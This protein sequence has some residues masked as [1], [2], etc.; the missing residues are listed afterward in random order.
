MRGLA[1]SDF[2]RFLQDNRACTPALKFYGP[3]QSQPDKI[4]ICD[5]DLPR[6]Q[7]KTTMFAYEAE[8]WFTS[9]QAAV[10]GW[11]HGYIP[12]RGQEHPTPLR[13]AVATVKI[14]LTEGSLRNTDEVKEWLRKYDRPAA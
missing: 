1:W 13:G 12:F 5:F 10:A 8:D 4:T 2:I 11:D 9:S 6:R 3:T 14:L 7:G